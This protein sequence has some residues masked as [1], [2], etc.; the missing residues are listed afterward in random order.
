MTQQKMQKK[1][2]YNTLLTLPLYLIFMLLGS[3]ILQ[4]AQKQLTIVDPIVRLL[5]FNTAFVR[6]MSLGESTLKETIDMIT[7]PQSFLFFLVTNKN[8]T[9][10]DI[11]FFYTK[12]MKEIDPTFSLDYIITYKISIQHGSNTPTKDLADHLSAIETLE[13]NFTID[14]AT[15]EKAQEDIWTRPSFASI[16]DPKSQ[17]IFTEILID[18]LNKEQKNKEQKL[19]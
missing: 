6:E 7:K 1:T 8:A 5:Y 12:I 16:N 9:K 18:A 10:E 17:Y 14:D 15:K 11:E 2:M 3:C 4:G 13:P 19:I